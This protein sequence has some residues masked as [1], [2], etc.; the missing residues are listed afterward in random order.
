M[1]EP[2]WGASAPMAFTDDQGNPATNDGAFRIIRSGTDLYITIQNRVDNRP[3]AQD[4]VFFA[5]TN[6]GS[7]QAVGVAIPVNPGTANPS[8]T[9]SNNVISYVRDG[10]GKWNGLVGMPSWIMPNSIGSFT[11]MKAEDGGIKWAVQFVVR[12]GHPDVN[13][14]A[15]SDF[16]FFTGMAAVDESL[17]VPAGQDPKVKVVSAPVRPASAR[18]IPDIYAPEDTSLWFATDAPSDRPQLKIPKLG[19]ACPAGVRFT[20]ATQIGTTDPDNHIVNIKQSDCRDS[21]G[22]PKACDNSFFARPEIPTGVSLTAGQL[23]AKFRIANWGAQ[24]TDTYVT[25]PGGAAVPNNA[26]GQFQFNCGVNGDTR[27]CGSSSSMPQGLPIPPDPHQCMTVEIS[28]RGT[29]NVNIQTPIIF[30][31]MR[32][33]SLSSKTLDAEISTVGLSSLLGASS[34]SREI[35][36]IVVTRNMPSIGNFPMF[37]D[38]FLLNWL[39]QLAFG[40]VQ[41]LNPFG[42]NLALD[43]QMKV[44]WPTYEVHTYYDTETTW[45]RRGLRHRVFKPMNSFGYYFSHD[46]VYF[47]F[48][49]ALG[50]LGVSRLGPGEVYSM[51]MADESTATVRTGVRTEDLPAFLVNTIDLACSVFPFCAR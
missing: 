16:R 25:I 49:H 21:L 34:A 17:P 44:I 48:T 22:I 2:R 9:S 8:A 20:S 3:S 45:V 39:K 47:G 12:L 1:N 28:R 4:S 10:T 26:S 43:D 46:G 42:R 13:L 30:R 15:G 23:Q 27:F 35:M 37:L 50:G 31:N 24:A 19:D 36:M 33:E 38:G 18:P 14:N 6:P 51:R 41:A 11:N 5:V 32:F 40:V 29:N 7:G